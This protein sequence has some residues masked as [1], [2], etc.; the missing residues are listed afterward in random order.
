[1]SGV[2]T[3]LASGVL[4]GIGYTVQRR[5]LVNAEVNHLASI[6]WWFGLSLLI[7]AET[8]G[9]VATVLVPA[10]VVVALSSVSVLTSAVLA[11]FTEPCRPGLIMGTASVITGSVLFALA[12]P[13]SDSSYDFQSDV[14]SWASL[15]Y[16]VVA[17]AACIPIHIWGRQNI[18]ALAAYAGIV[19]SLTAIW[20]RPLVALFIQQAWSRFITSPLPY[21]SIL[22]LV[23]SGPYAAAYLE[24]LGLR[25]FPQ[26]EWIPVHFVSCL[27][28]F[29]LAGEVVY[30][31][32][33]RQSFHPR[34]L[35]Y[36]PVAFLNVISGVAVIAKRI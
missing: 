36:L 6:T 4:N 9:G 27:I 13:N 8:L 18:V 5:V 1:M 34:M 25:Q 28:F 31:D 35:V 32:W 29:T 22:V 20:Y 14:V 23:I 15:A 30:M 11:A 24:P 10:S 16:H 21:L 2:I 17:I 26:T 7:I 33:Q 12:I 3:S 19:S